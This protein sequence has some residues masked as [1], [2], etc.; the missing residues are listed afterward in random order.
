MATGAQSTDLEDPNKTAAREGSSHP[1]TGKNNPGHV[2]A[3]LPSSTLPIFV[4]SGTNYGRI[5]SY[6]NEKDSKIKDPNANAQDKVKAKLKQDNSGAHTDPSNPTAA[7]QDKG[8]N[9]HDALMA[10]DPQ[11]AAAV[12]KKALQ[13]MIMLKQMD[14][15]TSPAGILA[16]ATGGLGGALSG[17]AGAVGLGGLQNALNGAMGG[18]AAGGLLA[19]S[20]QNALQSGM[21]GMLNGVAAGALHPAEIAKAVD[22]ATTVAHAMSA[23]T[24]GSPY[25]VD[26]V[27]QFGGP[28]F[29]LTPGSLAAKISLLGPGGQLQTISTVNGVRVTTTIYTSTNPTALHSMPVL[30]SIEHVAIGAAAISDIAGGLSDALGVNNPIGSALGTAADALGA[31]SDAASIVAGAAR[32]SSLVNNVMGQGLGSI[33]T[34]TNIAAGALGATGLANIVNGGIGNIVSGGLTKIL[35]VDTSGLLGAVGTLLPNMAG[36]INGVLNSH[37]PKTTLNSGAINAMAQEQTKVLALT[38]AASGAAK[39]IFGQAQAEAIAD[40]AGKAA[41]LAAQVGSFRAVTPFGDVVHS[42]A[43]GVAVAEVAG[44]AIGSI[45]QG[46]GSILKG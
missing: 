4:T 39:N 21:M 7:S 2:D 19:A 41:G 30:N 36:N 32:V 16:M 14:K 13:A 8:K 11:Q 43:A 27:A 40:L 15:L 20:A 6:G 25:A 5:A 45:S 44:S 3:P 18:I 46:I 23:I 1:V 35:G 9:I 22:T 29:G 31:A 33:S 37:L 26:A 24:T 34:A 12:L 38:K 10:A 28:A 17:V 42:I